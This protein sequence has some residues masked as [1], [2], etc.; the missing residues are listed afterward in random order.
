MNDLEQKLAPQT[1]TMQIIV[2]AMVVVP[3]IFAGVVLLI[4]SQEPQ[5]PAPIQ[6]EMV[7]RRGGAAMGQIAMGFGLIALFVQQVMGRFVTSQAVNNLAVRAMNEPER[8]GEAFMVGT[9]VSCAINEGAA[10]LNLIA[11]MS[12][13]SIYNLGMALLLIASN[14]I[15]M[16][17]VNKVVNWTQ[18]TEKRLSEERDLKG[19][20]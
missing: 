2:A 12:S 17:T 13:Q 6:G 10:F 14:A 15:K 3:L 19:N 7:E 16:P 18:A 5:N 20:G 8:L 9:I 1:R 4:G 11:Y